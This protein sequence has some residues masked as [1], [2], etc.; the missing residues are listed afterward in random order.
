MTG[1]RSRSLAVL[2]LGL[3]RHCRLRTAD[4]KNYE[5]NDVAG[6]RGW[7]VGG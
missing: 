5:I 4:T 2:T 3:F 7:H 1:S 6:G